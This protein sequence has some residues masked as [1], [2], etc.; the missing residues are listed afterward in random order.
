MRFDLTDLRLFLAVLDVGSIT[1][2]AT[3][4]GLSLAAASER[5]RDM[6][7]DGKV[8]LLARSRRGVQP[9]EAGDALAHHARLILRQT[10]HMQDELGQHAKG[11]RATIRLLANTAAMTEFLPVRLGPWLAAHP[12][13]DVDIRERQSTEIASAVRLGLAE[14]GILSAAVD[15]AGLHLRPFATDNLV[16]IVPRHHPFASHRALSFGAIIGENV[17]GLSDGALQ[18]HLDAQAVRAGFRFKMRVRVRTYE[19]VC[20]LVADGVGLGILP[21]TA[22][23][24]YRRPMQLAVLRMTDPWTKRHLA[25]CIREE[26]ELTPTALSLFEHL[27]GATRD[28]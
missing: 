12:Q 14:I 16:V 21:A 19:G 5:L 3:A 1:H 8:V 26:P 22:A 27:I 24:R 10:S 9:T 28:S 25:A 7:T 4:V 23:A 18:S 15:I 2:G 6:E 13:V 17:V 20:R 11:M